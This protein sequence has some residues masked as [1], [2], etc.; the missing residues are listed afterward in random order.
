VPLSASWAM[1]EAVTSASASIPKVILFPVHVCVQGASSA[2]SRL[3]TA[4]P[5]PSM[6]RKRSPFSSRI[7]S[8][9]SS[10]SRWAG[11]TLVTRPTVGAAISVRR[12]ISPRRFVPIS[13][14]AASWAPFIRKIVRGSPTRLLRLPSFLSRF[15]SCPMMAAAISFVVV[16]PVLPVTATTGMSNRARQCRA[17]S[18]SALSVSGTETAA[19]FAGR[20]LSSPSRPRSTRTPAAPASAAWPR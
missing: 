4:V 2:S 15:F 14:T 5:W 3:M 7:V 18:P 6:T 8:M 11:P 16:L 10:P 1:R 9:D 19:V 13:R 20:S 12:A 17:R